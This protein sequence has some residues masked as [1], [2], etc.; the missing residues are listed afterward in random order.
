MKS[1]FLIFL[2]IVIIKYLW[3]LDTK[4]R[5]H[6]FGLDMKNNEKYPS[7]IGEMNGPTLFFGKPRKNDTKRKRLEKIEWLIKN[8]H[9]DVLWRRTLVYSLGITPIIL[10]STNTE[11]NIRNVL[12]AGIFVFI[13]IYLSHTYYDHHIN[14][15]RIS[16]IEQHLKKLKEKERKIK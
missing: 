8:I 7:I 10:Y 15:Y 11:L 16:Y 1:I 9:R 13:V 3:S 4:D 2:I 14:H 5:I 12:S 6:P